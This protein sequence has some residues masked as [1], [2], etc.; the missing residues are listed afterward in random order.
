MAASVDPSTLLF[1]PTPPQ[2]GY[3]GAEAEEQAAASSSARRG[4]RSSSAAASPHS[5]PSFVKAEPQNFRTKWPE[6]SAYESSES[7]LCGVAA[8]EPFIESAVCSA[9]LSRATAH[10]LQSELEL[11]HNLRPHDDH[12]M[13]FSPLDIAGGGVRSRSPVESLLDSLSLDSFPKT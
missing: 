1:W 9:A 7:L 12:P 3:P 4:S 13:L 11:A 2:E 10:P 8:E 5:P 6:A